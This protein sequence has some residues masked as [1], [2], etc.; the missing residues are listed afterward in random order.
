MKLVLKERKDFI[1]FNK[2]KELQKKRLSNNDKII[3]KLIKTK[4][5]S[6]WRDPLI[7][8]LNKLI[9]RYA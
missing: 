8:Y 1:I 2:V 5:R 7:I 4:L 3:V 6:N 9:R